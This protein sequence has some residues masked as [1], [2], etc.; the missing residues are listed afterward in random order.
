MAKY[1]YDGHYNGPPVADLPSEVVDIPGFDLRLLPYICF[2]AI[3]VLILRYGCG[4]MKEKDQPNPWRC[5][6]HRNGEGNMAGAK[7][8][9][10]D[11]ADGDMRNPG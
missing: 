2:S 9:D 10:C 3:P 4:R 7:T 6:L 11:S 1:F 8:G 5:P